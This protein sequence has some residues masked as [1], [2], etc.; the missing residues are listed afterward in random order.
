ME[1]RVSLPISFNEG[2]FLKRAISPEPPDDSLIVQEYHIDSSPRLRLMGAVGVK[3]EPHILL[4]PAEYDT[5]AMNE[6]LARGFLEKGGG[7][8]W[9]DYDEYLMEKGPVGLIDVVDLTFN[10]YLRLREELGILG[11]LVIMGKSIG[12]VPAIEAM[13]RHEDDALCLILESAF[14]DTS[15]FFKAMGTI[16]EPLSE[17]PFSNK[18]KMAALKKAVLFLH[19]H[20]DSVVPIRDV[21]WL[22]CESRS[23]ATQFQI[24]P[25][26]DRWDLVN[27]AGPLY[28]DVIWQF[29]G[30]RMGRRPRRRPRHARRQG[31]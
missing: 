11:P 9:V 24:V 22:V 14:S 26:E 13:G 28:F 30:L 6:H 15:S 4:F 27:K 20:M 17:D 12:T 5:R 25:S 18:K 19:S 23:K 10:A 16:E 29:I 7:L 2:F 3:D 31:A 8:F 1:G 21:E